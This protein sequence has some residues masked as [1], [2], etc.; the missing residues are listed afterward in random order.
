VAELEQVVYKLQADVA[1][2]KRSFAEFQNQTRRTNQEFNNLATTMRT[3]VVGAMALVSGGMVAMGLEAGVTGIL[4]MSDSW[5]Q[6]SAQ[7]RRAGVESQNMAGIQDRLYKSSQALGVG[8]ESTVDT[9]N[10]IM[11]STKELGMT[12][13]QAM[14]LTESLNSAIVASGA[15]AADA[16]GGLYQLGQ[17]FQKGKLNGDEL[18][19]ISE[20]LPV[21]MDVIR[22]YA[23]KL[24]VDFQQ[25]QEKGGIT[26][27][28][29][30]AAFQDAQ[31]NL[32]AEAATMPDTMDKAMTRTKNSFFRAIGQMTDAGLFKPVIDEMNALA[33]IFAS[34]EFQQGVANIAR[35]LISIATTVA[36]NVGDM[37]A[38]G[39]ALTG[40]WGGYKVAGPV[41]AA[42]GGGAGFFAGGGGSILQRQLL[43][44]KEAAIASGRFSGADLEGLKKEV[45]DLR[46]A[47]G[48]N[49]EVTKSTR[50]TYQSLYPAAGQL[51]ESLGAVNDQFSKNNVLQDINKAATEKTR[52]KIFQ[53][54]QDA[55]QD[56][57]DQQALLAAFKTGGDAGFEQEQA[58]QRVQSSMRQKEEAPKEASE[59][60]LKKW[61]A[62]AEAAAVS[63]AKL[64][65]QMDALRTAQTKAKSEAEQAAEKLA[66]EKQAREEATAS[67]KQSLGEN[68]SLSAALEVSRESY[69]ALKLSIDAKNEALREGFKEGTAEFDQAVSGIEARERITSTIE[70]QKE[71]L[72]EV[73]EAKKKLGDK[74]EETERELDAQQRLADALAISVEEYRKVEAVLAAEAEVRA[75]S[76]QGVDLNTDALKKNALALAALR[77]ANEKQKAAMEKAA[78]EQAELFAEPMKEALRAV[79]SEISGFFEDILTDGLG[80]WE[81]LATGFRSIMIKSVANMGAA[82]IMNPG[83]LLRSLGGM[84]G[85]TPGASGT[86]TGAAALGNAAAGMGGTATPGTTQVAPGG[87]QGF[88]QNP[89]LAQ[90]LQYGMVGVGLGSGVGTMMGAQSATGQMIGGGLGMLAGGLIGGPVGAGIGGFLGS[91]IGGMFG[92]SDDNSGDNNMRKRWDPNRGIYYKEKIQ[93]GGEQNETIVNN[94]LAEVAKAVEVIKGVGGKAESNPQILDIKSGNNS[95]I[96]INGK[97]YG[98]VE[99]GIKAA[100]GIITDKSF[101]IDEK[102]DTTF[103]RILQNTKAGTAGELQ[104]D[105]TFGKEYDRLINKMSAS[106][107]P[108]KDLADS[109]EA[110]KEKAGSLGLSVRKLAEVQKEAVDELIKSIDEQMVGQ[111]RSSADQ[112]RNTF[113]SIIDPFKQV[114]SAFGA[115][116]SIVSPEASLKRGLEEFRN[117]AALADKDDMDALKELPGLGQSLIQMAQQFGGSGPMAS[118]II[119]EV[120]TNLN[121]IQRT[122]ETRQEEILSSFHDTYKQ[123]AGEQIRVMVEGFNR[124]VEELTTF[125]REVKLL[126]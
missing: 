93:E 21:V 96:T 24:G 8:Y 42:V 20:R 94:I 25:L 23:K 117:T 49:N 31:D 40:A 1:D 120:M 91:A 6:L 65:G 114:T 15:S 38:W 29:I 59:G 70:K 56:L 125:R 79:Q 116:A 60:D 102:G 86:G 92:G 45:L 76:T 50:Q 41:G 105:F 12:Q 7:M 103:K 16:A 73:A 121:S 100:L 26:A 5:N 19:S 37:Q 115:G 107:R 30:V 99:E 32:A 4:K 39:G 11:R 101:Y 75:A 69:D 104:Q 10:K 84:F 109:F 66:R 17:A 83:N 48:L 62:E 64:E 98:S 2:A 90:G 81:D 122:Q 61:T 97:K 34:E 82:A 78:E 51:A 47:M 72:E 89:K 80:T 95:G 27:K 67:I 36:N 110:A 35:N 22:D 63:T 18:V 106:V 68:I 123:T 53:A 57:K 74:E 33:N 85:S 119:R 44:G 14:N 71:A 28:F 112:I 46:T 54:A 77:S 111:L 13:G 52:D 58:R 43:A 118:A 108:V 124:M 3:R 88:L 9:F 87:V 126:S 55:K 113:S